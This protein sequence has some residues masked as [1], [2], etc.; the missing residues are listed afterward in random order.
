MKVLNVAAS[1]ALGI[2]APSVVLAASLCPP[3]GV[4]TDCNIVITIGP[5]GTITPSPGAA[6]VSTYDGSDDVLVGVVNNSGQAVSSFTLNGGGIDIFGFDGDG[7]DTFGVVEN[8]GNPDTSGYGGPNAF[9]TNISPDDST[10]T[11]NFITPIAGNGGFDYFS[12]EEAITASQ[13]TGGPGPT[14]VT[15]EPNTLLMFGTG[16]VALAG[17]IRRRVFHK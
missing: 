7:I 14:A 2:L 6:T 8:P 13:I 16:M 10:G 1:L 9:F 4:A 17:S 5:G 12:L 3:V 15:P 11:V